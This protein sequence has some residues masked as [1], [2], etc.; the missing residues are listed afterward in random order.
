ANTNDFTLPLE[1]DPG[2]V[3]LLGSVDNFDYVDRRSARL[4]STKS[5]GSVNTGLLTTQFGVGSDRAETARLTRGV[6]PGPSPFRFNRGATEGTYAR[7]TADFEFHPNVS[8]DFVQP[9]F[10]ARAHYEIGRG[11]LDWQR[12]QLSLAARQYL[13]ALSLA[14]HVDGGLL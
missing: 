14:L 8:G 9:G 2:I 10:G 12:M 11:E 7:G 13:G 3:A 1:E 5:L 4:P 6:I